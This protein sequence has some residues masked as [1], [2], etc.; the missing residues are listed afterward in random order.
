MGWSAVTGS[1]ASPALALYVGGIAW[2]IGYDTIY[3]HQDK[4]DDALI[5]LKSTALRF[6]RHTHRWLTGF[7]ALATI[8]FG[9]AAFLGGA[10]WPAYAGIGLMAMHFI[11]QLW[12]LDIDDGA[13][14]LG[15]F[16]ANRDA[17]LI[18][19]AGYLLTGLLP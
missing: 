19:L 8:C 18:V 13:V 4:E 3:A 16:R 10:G 9:L 2:T 6:G 15:L 17:G 1:L 5:G 14:C 7:Y 12:R 11:W